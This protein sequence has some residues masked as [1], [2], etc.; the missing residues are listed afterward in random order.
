MAERKTTSTKSTKQR[1]NVE[2]LESKPLQAVECPSCDPELATKRKILFVASEAR[3]FIATGGL[4][5]VI[6][7]L[8]QALAQD[9]AYDIRVVLP[10]YSDIKAEYRRKM[11]FLGNIYVP[12]SWRNQYCG[13]FTYQEKGVKFYFIDNEYYFKRSGCYGYYDDGERFAFFSRA[14]LEILPFIDFYPN[15]LHCHDWQTALSVI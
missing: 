6:G 12:L 9:P 14:S 10:L 2:V 3:P 15:I 13:I 7:S 8:P 4:A 5:D 11:A 1:K